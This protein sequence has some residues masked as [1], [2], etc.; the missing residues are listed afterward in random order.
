MKWIKNNR[1]IYNTVKNLS[2]MTK[3]HKK[4]IGGLLEYLWD[5]PKIPLRSWL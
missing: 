1:Y 5:D 3:L 4:K 2:H